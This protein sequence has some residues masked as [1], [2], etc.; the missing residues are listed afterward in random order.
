MHEEFANSHTCSSWTGS[1]VC[2]HREAFSGGSVCFFTSAVPG[3]RCCKQ[4]LRCGEKASL[5]VECGL[6]CLAARGILIP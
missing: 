3:L 4:A 5:A 1:G 6:R 2:P